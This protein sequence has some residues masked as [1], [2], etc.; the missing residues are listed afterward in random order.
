MLSPTRCRGKGCADRRPVP[1]TPAASV[2]RSRRRHSP[3]KERQIYISN[4]DLY[5]D[6][7]ARDLSNAASEPRS[8]GR[9]G[10]A[11]P[12]GAGRNPLP[13]RNRRALPHF[14]PEFS[15]KTAV[16]RQGVCRRVLRTDKYRNKRYTS[17]KWD[18]TAKSDRG[19]NVVNYEKTGGCPDD[20]ERLIFF[21]AYIRKPAPVTL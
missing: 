19:D 11:R 21:P 12:R 9:Q 5:D 8:R 13:A 17:E 1:M 16:R 18:L 2:D 4:S 15:R 20:I 14:S 7:G 6:A 3:S 10:F